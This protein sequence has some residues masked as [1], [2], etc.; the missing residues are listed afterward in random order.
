VDRAPPEKP[1]VHIVPVRVSG[2]YGVG[3]IGKF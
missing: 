2:G 3:A 1:E